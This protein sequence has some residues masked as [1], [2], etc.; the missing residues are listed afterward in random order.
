MKKTRGRDQGSVYYRAKHGDWYGYVSLGG[1]RRKY[2]TPA[3]TQKA[4]TQQITALLHQKDSGLRIAPDKLTVGEYLTNWLRDIIL[5]RDKPNT[6]S[7]YESIVRNH[8][9]PGI[10]GRPLSKLT[11]SE[12]KQFLNNTR[13]EKR[14]RA[15]TLVAILATLK[16]ALSEAMR[17]ELLD[18]NVAMLVRTDDSKN[19][20]FQQQ[21]KINVLTPNQAVQFLDSLEGHPWKPFFLVALA[22]GIRR[23]EVC[24]LRWRDIDFE[25]NAIRIHH[26][27]TDAGR[28]KGTRLSTLKTGSKSRRPLT[29]NP[30]VRD[31]LVLQLEQQRETRLLASD[32]WREQDYVFTNSFGDHWHPDTASSTFQEVLKAAGLC[33]VRLHDLRHTVATVLLSKGITRN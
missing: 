9:I 19:K 30:A 6:Y 5:P 22:T 29:M 23:G 7:F 33:R 17:D 32:L 3:K 2:I 12:V 18:R 8:L 15:A 26:S 28:G 14:L 11:P 20:V 24:A 4:A 10:G 25:H 21:E 13:R 27:I 16:A 1:G 31:A